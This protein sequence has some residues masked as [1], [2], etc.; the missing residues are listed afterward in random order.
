MRIFDSLKPGRDKETGHML[1]RIA[2][3]GDSCHANAASVS[4]TAGRRLDAEMD[5]PSGGYFSEDRRN[6][7]GNAVQGRRGRGI[8]GDSP[9]RRR[10][11]KPDAEGYS[12]ANASGE[13]WR[14]PKKLVVAGRDEAG[15]SLANAS[16]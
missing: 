7:I 10:R 3:P 15:Y 2:D 1:C 9:K 12:L 16:G 6:C 8:F 13:C 4:R 5:T 11:Q 14:R